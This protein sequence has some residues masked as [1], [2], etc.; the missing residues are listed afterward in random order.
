MATL[1][2]LALELR[3]QIYLDT[4]SLQLDKPRTDRRKFDDHL[5]T[6]FWEFSFPPALLF[7]NKQIYA[8][9]RHIFYGK[10]TWVMPAASMQRTANTLPP[11]A[12]I[13]FVRTA[14]LKIFLEPGRHSPDVTVRNSIDVNCRILCRITNLQALRIEC[15][16]DT[17]FP[18]YPIKRA[19]IYPFHSQSAISGYLERSPGMTDLMNECLWDFLDSDQA[20][21]SMVLQPLLTLP[22]TCSLQKGDICVEKRDVIMSRIL[23]RAFSNCLDA[24]IALR[25]SP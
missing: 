5:M 3:S 7:T 11:T 16:E 1:L 6:S 2:S 24:V 17:S 25:L 4:L 22:G 18:F 8:E 15:A 10:N 20:L 9:A 14:L 19:P 21:V 23:E 12:A 13:P